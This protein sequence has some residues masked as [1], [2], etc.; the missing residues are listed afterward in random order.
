MKH[1]EVFKSR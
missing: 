1:S